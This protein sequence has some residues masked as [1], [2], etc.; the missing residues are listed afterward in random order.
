MQPDCDCVAADRRRLGGLHLRIVLKPRFEAVR[1]AL[2]DALAGLGYLGL[3]EEER[4]TLEIV[5]AEALNNVVEHAARAGGIEL[6]INGAGRTLR[7]AV[8]DDGAPM[9]GTVAERAVLPDPSIP[10]D[11]G[12]GCF[13]INA[14]AEDVRYVT[15]AGRNRLSFCIGLGAGEPK[16]GESN[17]GP[18]H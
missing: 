11:G 7:C 14:L 6:R 17:G 16:R 3:S 9:A 15:R 18:L 12:F 10:G 13:L 2:A 5:L 8:I 1:T 4:G